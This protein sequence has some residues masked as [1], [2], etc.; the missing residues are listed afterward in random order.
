MRE[1]IVL[2]AVYYDGQ[3]ADCYIF[4]GSSPVF[5]IVLFGASNPTYTIDELRRRHKTKASPFLSKK[6]QR[7]QTSP[8]TQQRS[9]RRLDFSASR[10]PRNRPASNPP[11]QQGKRMVVKVAHTPL[12]QYCCGTVDRN[13]ATEIG[14]SL[15]HFSTNSYVESFPPSV[16]CKEVG[17]DGLNSDKYWVQR[18]LIHYQFEG[19][20]EIDLDVFVVYIFNIA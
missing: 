19:S 9:P 15:I 18:I 1:K 10:P 11:S 8:H 4:T 17:G 13:D 20:F 14:W 3:S 6:T 2:D 7:K 12:E 16:E 5:I